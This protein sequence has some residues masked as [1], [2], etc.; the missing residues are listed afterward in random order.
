[1]RASE[2]HLH[3]SEPRREPGHPAGQLSTI[4]H[5]CD[6]VKNLELNLS[7]EMVRKSIKERLDEMS[8]SERD[9][10][11]S[12]LTVCA[13][14]SLTHEQ[15]CE[16]IETAWTIVKPAQSDFQF[17]ED[18]VDVAW[19]APISMK[20]DPNLQKNRSYP[21]TMSGD[22]ENVYLQFA[23]STVKNQF[24]D[25]LQ[26]Q[27]PAGCPMKSLVRSPIPQTGFHF[28]RKMIRIEMTDVPDSITTTFISSRIMSGISEHC[29]FGEFRDGE[30]YGSQRR[31]SVMFS[32]N[33]W[34]FR[35]L[36]ETLRGYISVVLAYS[37]RFITTKLYFRVNCKGRRR[38]QS[39][40]F[41]S[42]LNAALK[43][44]QRIDIPLEFL[45]R[46]NLRM[47]LADAILV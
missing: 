23:S 33:D 11:E 45:E 44:L 3:R 6:R 36:F 22:K 8:R 37:P 7:D 20:M 40:G 32:V 26:S 42:S 39:H 4:K 19:S 14:W 29:E 9:V 1:M 28:A 43:E 27:D 46:R 34:A 35:H 13:T 10:R 12:T 30:A 18:P 47:Q 38:N 41:S 21:V 31:R 5:T 24:I 17:Q 2:V 25:F 15:I 16:F